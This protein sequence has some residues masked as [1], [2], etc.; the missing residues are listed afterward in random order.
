MTSIRLAC[1][2]V[3]RI[4]S[5][6]LINVEEPTPLWAKPFPRHRDLG[7]IRKSAEQ[8]SKHCS[9]IVGLSLHSCLQV[10]ALASDLAPLDGVL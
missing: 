5:S 9:S 10:P 7:Y 2:H 1:N 6:S 4:F 3:F 8:V